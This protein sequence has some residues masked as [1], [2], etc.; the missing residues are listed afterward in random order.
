MADNYLDKSHQ[1]FGLYSLKTIQLILTQ[2]LQS[3]KGN[4]NWIIIV[5]I[6]MNILKP[7]FY[8]AHNFTISI[9]SYC[10]HSAYK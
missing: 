2:A 1:C 8:L 5:N 3:L 4:E 6:S 7:Y 9:K 10:F